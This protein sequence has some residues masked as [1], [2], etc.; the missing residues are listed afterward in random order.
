MKRLLFWKHRITLFRSF[1]QIV[2]KS[3]C[4]LRLRQPLWFQKM[5]K[6]CRLR[7]LRYLRPKLTR[8]LSKSGICSHRCLWQATFWKNWCKMVRRGLRVRRRGRLSCS[9]HM[10]CCRMG[11]MGQ[12]RKLRGTSWGIRDINR[13][14]ASTQWFSD[15]RRLNHRRKCRN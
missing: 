1:M 8:R 12:D 13:N 14:I 5:L 9:R 2:A 3:Y 10:H 11:L 7:H 4:S 6:M 15:C